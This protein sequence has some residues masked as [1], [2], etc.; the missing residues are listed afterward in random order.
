MILNPSRKLSVRPRP[1]VQKGALN[2][3]EGFFFSHNP[4]IKQRA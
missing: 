1:W 2:F 4:K 3:V